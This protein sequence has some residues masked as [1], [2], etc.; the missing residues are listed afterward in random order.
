MNPIQRKHAA[1][2]LPQAQNAKACLFFGGSFD[3]PHLG[4]A[5]LPALAAQQ[6]ETQ[7]GLPINSCHLVYVPAGQSPHKK[8]PPAADTHRLAMLNLAMA[9]VDRPWSIWTQELDDGPLNPGEP[10]YWADTWSIANR[11]LPDSG[12]RFLIGADQA[13]AMHRWHRYTEFWKDAMVMMRDESRDAEGLIGALRD[14]GVWTEIDLEHWRSCCVGLP[15]I[16]WSS[17]EIRRQLSMLDRQKN[18][19]VEGL[20][21]GVQ[22]YI[23]ERELYLK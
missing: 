10:S 22:S 3:P 5:S 12:N 8:H 7:L 16:P 9:N 14:L 23:V 21:Q 2:P 18:T 11:M 4:H 6:L 17:S 19:P 13:L 1:I 20:D 15:M